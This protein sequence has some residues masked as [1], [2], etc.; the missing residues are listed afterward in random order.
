MSV[1]LDAMEH[2]WRRK[3]NAHPNLV[4]CHARDCEQVLAMVAECRRWR[5]VGEQAGGVVAEAKRTYG[6]VSAK[7]VDAL[8]EALRSALAGEKAKEER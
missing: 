5:K 6:G 3:L 1:D 2:D 7:N 8:N 4:D